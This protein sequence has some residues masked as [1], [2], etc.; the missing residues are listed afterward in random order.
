MTEVFKIGGTLIEDDA[1]RESFCAEFASCPGD[2]ILVH[3]G[4][5]GVTRLQEALG[6]PVVRK[7]G[8]RVT[9][10]PAMKVVT[11]ACAGW[12]N[13]LLV[14]TLQRLGCNAVGL[15]G[16]DGSVIRS[17]LRPPLRLSDGSV[18]DFGFVGD[19]T[20]SS[21]NAG[22][23]RSLLGLGLV[24]VL[25]PVNH[26]G[27]GTL[28]NTNADT[29]ASSVAAALGG[30]LIC[31]FDREGIISAQGSVIPIMNEAEFEGM[32]AAGS[33][34]EGMIPKIQAALSALR[35]GA[36]EAWIGKTRIV[37]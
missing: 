17:S 9:D 22:L 35:S 11:M 31:R 1:L 36:S 13:K 29:V 24:P 18:T 33:V 2:K 26:D 28:M 25:S 30:R 12:Y 37:L 4:G 5:V 16:C 3:G 27:R 23:L 8:R 34:S 14:A 19:V 6:I 32:R 20:P 21:V 10:A 7:E 15:S